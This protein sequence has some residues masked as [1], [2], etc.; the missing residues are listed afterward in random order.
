MYSYFG[1]QFE[2]FLKKLK[3]NYSITQQHTPGH[4]CQRKE[5]VFTQ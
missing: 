4:L 1:K 2:V 5:D 3:C